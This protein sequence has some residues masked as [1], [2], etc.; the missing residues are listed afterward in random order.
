MY[1]NRMLSLVIFAVAAIVV[2]INVVSL[3]LD[4]LAFGIGSIGTVIWISG[5]LKGLEGAFWFVSG[6]LWIVYAAKNGQDGLLLRDIFGVSLYAVGMINALKR[7][8]F[9]LHRSPAV[10]LTR[11][12]RRERYV[13]YLRSH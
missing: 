7:S 6:L 1:T 9:R 2:S 8:G 13:R 4:W 3:P 11:T 12:Q 5:R 10:R